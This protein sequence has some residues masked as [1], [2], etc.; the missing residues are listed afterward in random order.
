MCSSRLICIRNYLRK[1]HQHLA[2]QITTQSNIPMSTKF[3]KFSRHNS[4]QVKKRTKKKK[5][6]P[7]RRLITSVVSLSICKRWKL[8][9]FY[10]PCRKTS[11]GSPSHNTF[12]WN[13][14]S[15]QNS[16]FFL[17]FFFFL[18]HS[19]ISIVEWYSFPLTGL[20]NNSHMAPDLFLGIKENYL[21]INL[22]LEGNCSY[23]RH[24][25][26]RH[27]VGRDVSLRIETATHDVRD[28]PRCSVFISPQASVLREREREKERENFP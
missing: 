10:D 27:T 28:H 14:S 7:C 12:L 16:F 19:R 21:L 15:L 6:N 2:S 11:V 23:S 4:F 25:T 1:F 22:S 20:N 17:F 13:I 24:G 26:Y 18:F 3:I 5:I 9:S 8:S